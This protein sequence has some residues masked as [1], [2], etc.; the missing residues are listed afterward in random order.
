MPNITEI[1]GEWYTIDIP[2]D[3]PA[4]YKIYQEEKNE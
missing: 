2:W 3:D 4:K 1:N